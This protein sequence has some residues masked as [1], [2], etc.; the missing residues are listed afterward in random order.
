LRCLIALLIV[1]LTLFGTW[2]LFFREKE[3]HYLVSE[4]EEVSLS[5]HVESK[6]TVENFIRNSSEGAWELALQYL[7]GEALDRAKSRYSSVEKEELISLKV[8]VL[9]ENDLYAEVAADVSTKQK[10]GWLDRKNYLFR[11]RNLE[12]KWEIFDQ[13]NIPFSYSPEVGTLSNEKKKV[14]SDYLNLSAA[15]RWEEAGKYLTG[16]RKDIKKVETGNMAVRNIEFVQLA[17]RDGRSLVEAS[18]VLQSNEGEKGMRVLFEI[19]DVGGG[20]YISQAYK[21]GG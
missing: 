19:F 17:E 10:G 14:I 5:T 9:L 16:I 12:G 8:D 7:T 3:S 11:L 13:Q 2:Y 1:V 18:Y 4:K 21:V 6:K 15:G 20:I